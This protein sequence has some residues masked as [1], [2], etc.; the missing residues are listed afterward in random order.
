MDMFAELER[1]TALHRSGAITTEEFVAAKERL[2]PRASPLDRSFADDLAAGRS[3]DAEGDRSAAPEALTRFWAILLHLS[4]F[5]G[6]LIPLAGFVVP[7]VIWQVQKDRL[8]D[9]DR[10]GRAVAN[11]I[12]S[13]V[14]Y[15]F[16]A[17]ILSF[18]LIGIPLMLLV[19]LLGI[20]WP[21]VGAIKAADGKVWK[22]PVSIPFF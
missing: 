12:I 4:Q 8:P 6:Y 15:G 22:Y 7:I 11:W 21:I 17:F 18:V 19:G 9:I 16:L 14:L 1:L 13:W 3:A 20:A 5:A 2:L 10:H